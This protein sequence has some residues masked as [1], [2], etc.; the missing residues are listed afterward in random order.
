MLLVEQNANYAIK[1]AD[2]GY[3]IESG[4]IVLDGTQGQLQIMKM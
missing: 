4:K 3:I 1:A 2:Y